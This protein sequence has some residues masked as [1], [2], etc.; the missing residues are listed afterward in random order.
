MKIVHIFGMILVIATTGLLSLLFL[1]GFFHTVEIAEKE[2]GPYLLVYATH[3]GDYKETGK[4]MD[5]VYQTLKDKH[6]VETTRGFG[7]FFD[8]PTEVPV[9]KLR[10]I[11]GCIVDGKTEKE[12]TD[13]KSGYR[14]R[15]FPASSAVVAEFPYKNRFSIILGIMKVY[16]RL[17]LYIKDH[18]HPQTPIMELYDQPAETIRYIAPVSMRKD[19]FESF[20]RP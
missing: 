17:A 20:L 10:S 4:I 13:L 9:E 14:V 6:H 18:S 3:T 8:N 5:D 7:L 2:A 12:V 15:E 16:P 1:S 11:A 19:E